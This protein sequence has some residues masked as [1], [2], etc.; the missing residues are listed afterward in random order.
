M[1]T[2]IVM[3]GIITSLMIIVSGVVMTDDVSAAGEP[4]QVGDTSYSSLSEAIS[5]ASAGDTIVM[6]SDYETSPVRVNKSVTLDLNGNTL[7]IKDGT[8]YGLLIINAEVRIING[9]IS[10]IRSQGNSGVEFKAIVVTN[11]GS[12]L[13]TENLVIETYTPNHSSKFNYALYIQSEATVTLNAGTTIREIDQSVS[14][15]TSGVVGIA[16][17]GP[18]NDS[19]GTSSGGV[20]TLKIS[21]ATVDVMGYAIAGKGSSDGTSITITDGSFTSTGSCVVYHPQRGDLTISGGEFTGVSGIQYCGNGKLTISGGVFRATAPA[22]DFP[23]K[24]SDQND[25]STE[26]GAALSIISRGGGYQ[27]PGDEIIVNITGGTFISDNNSPINSYRLQQKEENGPWFTGESTDLGSFVG[28]VNI[29]GGDFRAAEGRS[30]IEF[31][32]ADQDSYEVSGGKF[33]SKIDESLISDGVSF[34]FNNGTMYVGDDVNDIPSYNPGYD[35]DEGLPPFIPAQP[36]E[37][38]DT[39]TIVACAAAAAVA[40]ILAVFLV[41]DRKG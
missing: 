2:K 8:D 19:S 36:A 31:D 5:G 38:D 15:L 26:D 23:Q 9:T 6:T 3:A 24:P 17:L 11:S 10:D 28:A 21:D 25:G 7:T 34:E 37:D 27:R 13:V 30:P 39:V 32:T 20:T 18:D 41:I 22:S 29:T 16:I 14:G 35:D 12:E 40:A 4:F 1:N 33:N